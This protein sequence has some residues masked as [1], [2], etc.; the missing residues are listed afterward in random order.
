[1]TGIDL[2]LGSVGDL[3][4]EYGWAS[5]PWVAVCIRR[6]DAGGVDHTVYGASA[7][8]VRER[9]RAAYPPAPDPDTDPGT[10]TERDPGRE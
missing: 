3:G 7:T 9:V 6:R 10:D 1:M 8:L 2:D 4:I 5:G